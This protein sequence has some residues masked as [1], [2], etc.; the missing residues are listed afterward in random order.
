[1]NTQ[2]AIIT[3]ATALTLIDGQGDLITEETLKHVR[4][5][6]WLL[7]TGAKL[8][9]TK[10]GSCLRYMISGYADGGHDVEMIVN[11]LIISGEKFEKLTRKLGYLPADTMAGMLIFERDEADARSLQYILGAKLDVYRIEGEP[12]WVV[13]PATE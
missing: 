11:P 4:R 9:T 2:T 5:T 3:K 8:V 12:A 13:K 10:V 6:G 7:K 1:M